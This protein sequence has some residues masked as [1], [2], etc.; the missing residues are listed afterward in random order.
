MS[1]LEYRSALLCIVERW[2]REEKLNPKS[3]RMTP[4]AWAMY[5]DAKSALEGRFLQPL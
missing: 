3:E 5:H 2:E 4:L 1:E